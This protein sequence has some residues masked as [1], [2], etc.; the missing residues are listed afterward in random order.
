MSFGICKHFAVSF[1][2]KCDPPWIYNC[3][4]PPESRIGYQDSWHA[5]PK[6]RHAHTHGIPWHQLSRP[7][8]SCQLRVEQIRTRHQVS[9]Q[10][11]W[12][13]LALGLQLPVEIRAE[14]GSWFTA[15]FASVHT[16]CLAVSTSHAWQHRN[17]SMSV[18][19]LV[20]LV[21]LVGKLVENVWKWLKHVH[22][23]WAFVAPIATAGTKGLASTWRSAEC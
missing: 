9:H 23:S 15:S 4:M 19:G 17:I 14:V 5:V 21:G 8:T 7:S 1:P 20:G 22:N 10:A 18:L 13:S 12:R 2:R 16:P 6:R 11:T 3:W